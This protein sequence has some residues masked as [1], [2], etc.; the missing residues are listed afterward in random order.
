MPLLGGLLVGLFSGLVEFLLRYVAKRAALAI[1]AVALLTAAWATAYAAVSLLV[2][3]VAVTLP[4]ALS[5][6]LT[7]IFP[8]NTD[9][10]LAGVLGVDAVVAAMRLY[11]GSVVTTIRAA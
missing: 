7:A 11:M 1:A 6:W 9:E 3:G 8:S 5:H 10:V 4:E 2:A